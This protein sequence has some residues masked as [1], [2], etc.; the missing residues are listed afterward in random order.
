MVRA[1]VHMC[2]FL[3]VYLCVY[4][5]TTTSIPVCG[6]LNG[7]SGSVHHAASQETQLVVRLELTYD[8][9]RLFEAWIH[10]TPP[11]PLPSALLP[12]TVPLSWL[13]SYFFKPDG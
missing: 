4:V 11:P 12:S 6:M 1:G 2:V 13:L 9:V 5:H 8:L 10:Q 7:K 3:C